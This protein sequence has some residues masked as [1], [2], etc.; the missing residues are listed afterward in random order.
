MH[1]KLQN[2]YEA[3]DD[4]CSHR[5][6]AYDI[7]CDEDDL[8]G[9]M[10]YK[11]NARWAERLAKFLEP[12]VVREGLYMNKH[13][14]RGGII[15]AFSLQAIA[16]TTMEDI[17]RDLDS[18]LLQRLDAVMSPLSERQYHN[19]DGAYSERQTAFRDAIG[20]DSQTF[21]GY[22][23]ANNHRSPGK[24]RR[25]KAKSGKVGG[26]L[27][28]RINEALDGMAAEHQPGDLIERSGGCDE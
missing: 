24:R 26:V 27:E 13:D 9:Y 19:P 15:L 7:V 21:G 11:G 20:P 6:V 14:V 28:S 4:W 5:N 10:F 8:Q 12:M 1:L 25:A 17:T 23:F 3:L 18:P 2:L 16:E 22:Q